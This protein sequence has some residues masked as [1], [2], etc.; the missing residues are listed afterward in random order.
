[1][2][3]KKFTCPNGCDLRGDPIDEKNFDPALH[4]DDPEQCAS[5]KER[6][7]MC[8]CLPYGDLPPEERFFSKAIGLYHLGEDRTVEWLCVLCGAEW[9]T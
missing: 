7:G 9:E 4:N 1:M 2:T 6:Y 8:F 3:S 5:S